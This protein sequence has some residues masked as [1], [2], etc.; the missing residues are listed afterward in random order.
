MGTLGVLGLWTYSLM[1]SVHYRTPGEI[2]RGH[3]AGGRHAEH[4]A[5][6]A[7]HGPPIALWFIVEVPVRAFRLAASDEYGTAPNVN[8]CCGTPIVTIQ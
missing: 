4:I 3:R 2:G 8:V 6:Q 7:I 5:G 1:E